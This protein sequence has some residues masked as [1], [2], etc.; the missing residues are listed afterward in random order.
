MVLEKNPLGTSE[1]RRRKRERSAGGGNETVILSKG[2]QIR[3]G[4]L[5]GLL[6]TF[7]RGVPLGG[8]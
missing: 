7:I 1:V 5:D 8:D 4:P 6:V 3:S 2:V